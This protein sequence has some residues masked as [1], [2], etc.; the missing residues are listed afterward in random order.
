[1]VPSDN[2]ISKFKTKLEVT[3]YLTAF[4]PPAL[5]AK[6]P[7]SEQEPLLAGSGG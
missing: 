7:P 5:S 6:F 3:P 1:M 2:T 4:G